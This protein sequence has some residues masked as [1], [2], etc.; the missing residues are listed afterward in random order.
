MLKAQIEK[1]RC[2]FTDVHDKLPIGIPNGLASELRAWTRRTFLELR[3]L[4]LRLLLE[5]LRAAL[6]GVEF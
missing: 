3:E 2:S 6:P 4:E 1:S 5:R